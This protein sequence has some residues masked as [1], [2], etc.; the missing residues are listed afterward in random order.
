MWTTR[1]REFPTYPPR[2][3]HSSPFHQ[4]PMVEQTIIAAVSAICNILSSRG[5]VVTKD[6]LAPLLA[7]GALLDNYKLLNL[8]SASYDLRVGN[9]IWCQGSFHDLDAQAP[10]FEIPPYSYAIVISKEV[11]KL[12]P[13]L[14][15]QFDIKV[16]H[17]LSGLI[18]SNGPQVDPG[19]RGDLFC[20]LFNGSSRPI[21]VQMDDHFSTIQFFTT[22][23][24][25][26]R[27]EGQ[28]S[29]R[30]R[31]R[32][33]MTP[34]TATGP[35]GAIFSEIEKAKTDLRKEM[36]KDRVG[37][38]IGIFAILAAITVGV[39]LWAW[40]VGTD[41]QKAAIEARNAI[42]S[43]KEIR[44]PNIGRDGASGPPRTG[45]TSPGVP[46]TADNKPAQ[47]QQQRSDPKGSSQIEA[48]PKSEQ[49]KQQPAKQKGSSQPEEEPKSE[50]PSD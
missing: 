18:L 24:N 16:S 47:P 9:E 23:R 12:P 27:Y 25:A 22:T 45:E 44:E 43:L 10:N 46:G 32:A 38:Y 28:Y 37:V 1:Q 26:E 7:A 21:P 11:A 42:E 31:L 30:Q 34:E 14:T 40:S 3:H 29:L 41:A 8:E 36:P 39:A 6:L 48:E 35:G 15:G 17:F 4:N 49:P 5:G 20:L 50:Q 33:H 19:Y 13:F 2:I